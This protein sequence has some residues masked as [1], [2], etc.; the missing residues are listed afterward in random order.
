MALYGNLASDGRALR[1]AATVAKQADL[2]VFSTETGNIND[3]GFKTSDLGILKRSAGL[4]CLLTFWWRLII[5]NK[6]NKYDILYVHDYYLILPGVL[7]KWASGCK[8][9]YD[10]HE[11]IVREPGQSL[12]LQLFGLMEQLCISAADCVFATNKWR[13]DVMIKRYKLSLNPIIVENIPPVPDLDVEIVNQTATKLATGSAKFWGIY[14]GYISFTRGIGLFL[15]ALKGL[16]SDFGLI[17]MG[18]GPDLEKLRVMCSTKEFHGR[19]FVLP[20][21]PVNK[22]RSVLVC[23]NYSLIYYPNQGQNNLL[24]ASNKL[25]ESIHAGLPIVAANRIPLVTVVEGECIGC[26][27]GDHPDQEIMAKMWSD[28]ILQCYASWK[29]FKS[30][31]EKCSTNYQ[32]D[33]QQANIEQALGGLIKR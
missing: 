15:S 1:S 14:Q 33:H 21:V 19:V 28:A 22:V 30:N 3:I 31:C 25:Y 9:I 6:R 4:W 11:L 32:W 5:L 2:H 16:P 13:A 7:C 24:C 26:V 10:A 29:K 20:A 23:A 17:I 8:L 18:R 12:R 27:A